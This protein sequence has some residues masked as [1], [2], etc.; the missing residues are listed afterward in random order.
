MEGKNFPYT[1]LCMVREI[2][3]SGTG[4]LKRLADF[5]DGEFKSQFSFPAPTY[6][7]LYKREC[8]LPVGFIGVFDWRAEPHRVKNGRDWIESELCVDKI[9]TEIIE[10]KNCTTKNDLRNKL[11]SGI[12]L[13][14]ATEK[15]LIIYSSGHFPDTYCGVLCIEDDFQQVGD[16]KKVIAVRLPIFEIHRKNFF[17][18][19]GRIFYSKLYT[20]NQVGTFHTTSLPEFIKDKIIMRIN[21][22]NFKN[23]F[24]ESDLQKFR[25]FVKEFSA[26]DFYQEIAKDYSIS[27]EQ[28]KKYVD[29][30]IDKYDQYLSTEIFEDEVFSSIILHCPSLLE[31]FKEIVAEK[32]KKNNAQQISEAN[33][34]LNKLHQKIDDELKNCLDLENEI[35]NKKNEL[36]DISEQIKRREEFAAEVEKKIAQRIES[37]QKNAADFVSEM[38]FVSP[39]FGGVQNSRNILYR[40]GEVVKGDEV[41]I[42]D[43]EDF[44]YTLET[45]LGVEGTQSENI[46]SFAAYLTVAYMNKILLLL[47]GPNAR[48][49]ADVFSATLTG[50]TAAIFDCSNVNSLAD[51]E[52]I[53]NSDDEIIAVLNPFAPNFIAYLPELVNI[54]EKFIFAIHPFAE[55]LKIEPRSFYNYFLP[56]FT[57]LIIDR[58]P[59]R[60]FST[61]YLFSEELKQELKQRYNPDKI[62]ISAEKRMQKLKR[63]MREF[64]QEKK[65]VELFADFPLAYVKGL[66]EK[67]IDNFNGEKTI[68]EKIRD[69][70]GEG[71]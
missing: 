21:Q 68:F 11:L 9:P 16:K 8:S 69:F 53:S 40:A 14:F 15:V 33:V 66:E 26:E 7:T 61:K 62:P 30:F 37:A 45:E 47:A 44:V 22:T 42:E 54:K 38:A 18:I 1:S 51:L 34:Q 67:F 20:N 24:S 59:A 48:D 25:E 6:K 39:N 55:D 36:T 3:D 19:E 32:W 56:V 60:K 4:V 63:D 31:K 46:L 23:N 58:P 29:V 50:K 17:Q 27:S 13:D 12:K 52:I 2:N 57:E 65:S 43:L 49:I 70:L 35:E 5:E 28:A 10:L 71:S 64:V 41:E